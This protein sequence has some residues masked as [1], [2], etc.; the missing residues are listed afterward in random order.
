MKIL[1]K[2]LQKI[3]DGARSADNFY[4][5]PVAVLPSDTAKP[6]FTKLPV[7]K[8]NLNKTLKEMYQELIQII[9]SLPMGLLLC[10]GVKFLRKSSN[11]ILVISHL[12]L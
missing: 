2:Y 12:M 1:D 7:G 6:W 8:N 5:T 4:L 3:P 9:V 11:N 10:F